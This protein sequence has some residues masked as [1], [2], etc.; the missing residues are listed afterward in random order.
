[1]AQVR[2]SLKNVGVIITD[3]R[4]TPLR[5]GVTGFSIAYSGFEPLKN[6][7]GTKDILEKDLSSQS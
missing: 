6:Y 5:W 7:I 3:S 1:M 4:T 2:F